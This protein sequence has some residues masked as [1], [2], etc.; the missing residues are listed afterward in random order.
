MGLTT[1]IAYG[2]SFQTPAGAKAYLE[3]R[4]GQT[5]GSIWHV[6]NNRGIT[7]YT[8]S[9]GKALGYTMSSEFGDNTTSDI[10]YDNT[11]GYT[12][13]NL[14]NGKYTRIYDPSSQTAVV[15]TNGNGVFDEGDEVIDYSK[16][17]NN[18]E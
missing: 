6:A 7:N 11:T 14:V 12:Y 18:E 13:S 16:K 4:G 17:N 8:D 1:G 5:A 2:T 3:S 15:D 10:F 9:D